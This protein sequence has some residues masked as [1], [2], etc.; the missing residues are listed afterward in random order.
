MTG[1]HA[2]GTECS[3]STGGVHWGIGM[4]YDFLS[5][6]IIPRLSISAFYRSSMA[7]D[8]AASRGNSG[9]LCE[10]HWLQDFL[11]SSHIQRV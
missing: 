2:E 3:R 9:H 1:V 11:Y 4:E 8:V 7:F 10:T 6:S 5:F